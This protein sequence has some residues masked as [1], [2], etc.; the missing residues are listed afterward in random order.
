MTPILDGIRVLKP[1]DIAAAVVRIV[2][3]D[4]L[5]GEYL[6]VANEPTGQEEEVR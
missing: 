5:A 1:E 4:T 3:D 6:V 2:E